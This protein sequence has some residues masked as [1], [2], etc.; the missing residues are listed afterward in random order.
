MLICDAVNLLL[1]LRAE[2]DVSALINECDE[3]F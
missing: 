1:C 3:K 2:A